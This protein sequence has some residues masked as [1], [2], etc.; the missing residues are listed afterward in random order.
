M[1]TGDGAGHRKSKS[2]PAGRSVPRRFG[3]HK[4]LEY[5][6][7]Q[8]LREP[9]AIVLDLEYRTP[10]RGQDIQPGHGRHT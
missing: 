4:G 7:T 6:L 5:A 3:P 10:A 9:G 2:C 1:N 8:A